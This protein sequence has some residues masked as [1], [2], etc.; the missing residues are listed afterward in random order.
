[1]ER[2]YW[3]IIKLLAFSCWLLALVVLDGPEEFGGSNAGTR[4]KELLLIALGGCTGSD[5]ATISGYLLQCYGSAAKG[6]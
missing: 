4:P 1:M 6:S 3:G 5:V 2:R